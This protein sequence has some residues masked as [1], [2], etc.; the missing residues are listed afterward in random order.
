MRLGCIGEL[1][2][3]YRGDEGGG[4]GKGGGEV[5]YC[6]IEFQTLRGLQTFNIKQ[7]NQLCRRIIPLGYLIIV[8]YINNIIIF[9]YLYIY[10]SL[11]VINAVCVSLKASIK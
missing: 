5:L 2:Q 6:S 3:R 1:D 9:I 7:I 4:G 8:S 11:G 10:I